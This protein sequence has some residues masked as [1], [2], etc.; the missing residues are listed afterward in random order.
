MRA[1]TSGWKHIGKRIPRGFAVRRSRAERKFQASL[2]AAGCRIKSCSRALANLAKARRG[3]ARSGCVQYRNL[4]TGVRSARRRILDIGGQASAAQKLRRDI[5][6]CK[7]NRKKEL[8]A[9]RMCK[10]QPRGR[11]RPPPRPPPP[12]LYL[13]VGFISGPRAFR[14][15]SDHSYLSFTSACIGHFFPQPEIS[16]TKKRDASVHPAMT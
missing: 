2:S 4:I 6:H 15:S 14:R 16:F 1:H 11:F 7:L 9:T 8:N 12:L 13:W 5:E 10:G 3:E